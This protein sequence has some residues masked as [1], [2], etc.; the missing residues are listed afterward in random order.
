MTD[1]GTFMRRRLTDIATQAGNKITEAGNRLIDASNAIEEAEE[2][3]RA[4]YG[5]DNPIIPGK[6]GS[7]AIMACRGV[8]NAIRDALVAQIK[9]VRNNALY[10]QRLNEV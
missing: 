3:L 7:D 9:A 5:A 10:I 6:P 1:D 8:E 2:L 4:S